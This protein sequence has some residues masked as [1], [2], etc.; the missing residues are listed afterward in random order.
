MVSGKISLLV[1]ISTF[2]ISGFKSV[3]ESFDKSESPLISVFW[4][5][6]L[7]GSGGSCWEFDIKLQKI[8]NGSFTCLADT[9]KSSSSLFRLKISTFSNKGGGST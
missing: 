4:G 8:N 9:N 3:I 1:F 6:C 7:Y 2:S 5:G